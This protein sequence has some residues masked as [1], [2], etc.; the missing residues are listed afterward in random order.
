MK[1]NVSTRFVRTTL[2]LIAI[3]MLPT[4]SFAYV[5]P[6]AGLS[7]IGSLLA[8]V[9]AVIIAIFGFL[10]FP[11]RRIL[12]K[13]K[14]AAEQKTNDAAVNFAKPMDEPD[15]SETKQGENEA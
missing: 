3:M 8:L 2:M 13:R 1:I 10:W 14:Q 12:R 4:N 5:G 15:R 6:G 7:I 11:L 9:A